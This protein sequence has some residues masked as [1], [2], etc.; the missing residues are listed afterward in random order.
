MENSLIGGCQRCKFHNSK[1]TVYFNTRPLFKAIIFLFI[2]NEGFPIIENDLS[3]LY[4]YDTIIIR[5]DKI[6]N[7]ENR[8]NNHHIILTLDH[9]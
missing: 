3:T 1:N 4:M 9:L 6:T 2:L 8:N 7:I 5:G